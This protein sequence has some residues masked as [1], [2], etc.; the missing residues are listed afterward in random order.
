MYIMITFEYNGQIYKPSNLE[1]K[2]KKLHIT[3]ND[4][5][6]IS[7][8]DTNKEVEIQRKEEENKQKF[9]IIYLFWDTKCKG[10]FESKT[11]TIDDIYR[12][13][14]FVYMGMCD[15]YDKLKD[16]KSELFKQAIKMETK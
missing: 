15:S 14:D 7:D 11:E 6:I 12:K 8:E 10:W 1:K 13:L 2:L 16:M 4:I 9:D 5:K 3:M